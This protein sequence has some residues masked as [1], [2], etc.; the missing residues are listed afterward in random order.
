[1]DQHPLVHAAV[2][3]D[4]QDKSWEGEPKGD[5]DGDVG[6]ALAARTK[7]LSLLL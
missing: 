1:M 2:G 3:V 7:T 6:D 4:Q 5:G